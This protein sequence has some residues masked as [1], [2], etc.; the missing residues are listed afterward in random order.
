MKHIGV[1]MTESETFEEFLERLKSLSW[2][3]GNLPY[4]SYLNV[5]IFNDLVAKHVLNKINELLEMKKKYL[6]LSETVRQVELFVLQERTDEIQ[7]LFGGK[8]RYQQVPELYKQK[9]YQLID[10]MI[11]CEKEKVNNLNI[12]EILK[13]NS[14]QK[15]CALIQERISSKLKDW[16]L[17]N[18]FCLTRKIA[19][20]IKVSRARFV[21]SVIIEKSVNTI[22]SWEVPVP[23]IKPATKKPENVKSTMYNLKKN[24]F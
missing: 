6:E 1:I 9:I 13:Q 23:S 3:S 21:L 8:K 24:K 19:G 4:R 11:Y 17:D 16:I 15:D 12:S 2:V 10:K 5:E 22:K 7:K 14:T 18:D 20:P